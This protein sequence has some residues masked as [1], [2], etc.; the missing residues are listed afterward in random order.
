MRVAL[1]ADLAGRHEFSETFLISAEKGDGVDDL[2][3]WL[4]DTLPEGP[5]HCRRHTRSATIATP[6]KSLSP[7]CA[8]AARRWLPGRAGHALRVA[9]KARS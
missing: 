7:C 8:I 3:R 5:W 4:A 1:V 2:R 6:L 9:G